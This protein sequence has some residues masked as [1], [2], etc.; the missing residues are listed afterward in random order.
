M[1]EEAGVFVFEICLLMLVIVLKMALFPHL[2]TFFF[3]FCT[4]DW[5]YI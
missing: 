4:T 5:Q 1:L 3:F 2:E